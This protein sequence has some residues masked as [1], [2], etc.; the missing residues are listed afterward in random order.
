MSTWLLSILG[1]TV[2]GVLVELLLTDNPMSKFIRSVYAFFI[3]FVIVQPI[4]DFF[5]NASVNV[6]GAI[7][8]DMVLLQTINANS[9]VAFER[10]A[11]NVLSSSGYHGVIVTIDYDKNAAQF[12]IDK[13]YVNAWNSTNNKINE[14]IRIV[15]AVCNVKEEIVEV[16][17]QNV[18]S[19]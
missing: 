12:K 19:S 10:N 5:R 11:E 1:I 18:K 7:K 14:I 6:S 4:P 9:A 8:T 17:A 13:I 15:A 2:V 3:L 16:F